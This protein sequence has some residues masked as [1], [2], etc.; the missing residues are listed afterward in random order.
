MEPVEAFPEVIEAGLGVA[1]T[2]KGLEVKD[3]CF[4]DSLPRMEM[5]EEALGIGYIDF[6]FSPL[7]HQPT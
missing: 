2:L 1:S 7:F 5:K 6:H 4:T 3:V